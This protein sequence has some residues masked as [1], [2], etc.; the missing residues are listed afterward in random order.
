M[1]K[2]NKSVYLLILTIICALSVCGASWGVTVGQAVDNTNLIWTGNWYGETSDAHDGVDAAKGFNKN[3]INTLETTVK[4]P[5]TLKFYW[6][7][8]GQGGLVFIESN[9]GSLVYAPIT[10]LNT[11][12]YSDGHYYAGKSWEQVTYHVGTGTHN[13]HWSLY[14]SRYDPGSGF[15]MYSD[16]YGFLDQVRWIPAPKV[17]STT[18]K[19]GANGISR[20]SIIAIKF[21]EK[22]GKSSNWSKIAV[23]NKYGHAVSTTKWIRGNTLYI[24][25]NSKR[26]SYSYYS[27]YIPASA[28]KDSVGNNLA[29]KYS[30]KFKTGRY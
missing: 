16:A 18:P 12:T 30:F 5:G 13:V 6:K 29:T 27:V 17:T 15:Y 25:T 14:S 4:G 24:K 8:S 23:K 28:V 7:Y 21:S 11:G 26:S 10:G 2:I 19:N 3:S 22:I 9:V 20:T 1:N